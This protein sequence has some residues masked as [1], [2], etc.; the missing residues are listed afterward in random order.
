MSNKL[1]DWTDDYREAAETHRDD[2]L[3]QGIALAR[4][5]RSVMLELIQSDP[6]AALAAALPRTEREKLPREIQEQLETIISARAPLEVVQTC[7][8]PDEPDKCTHDHELYRSVVIDGRAYIAHVY[9]SRLNDL[10]IPHSSLH[11]IAID[12]HIAVSE[13]RVRVGCG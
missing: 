6:Q 2:L 4:E 3:E 9:G 10:S 8:H 5:R 12:G 1:S 13:S 7:F 11:G